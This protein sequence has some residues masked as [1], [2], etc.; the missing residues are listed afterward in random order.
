MISG[1]QNREN[2]ITF[3]AFFYPSVPISITLAGSCV[4]TSILI[5]AIVTNDQFLYYLICK[6]CPTWSDCI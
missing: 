1:I 6:V 4:P 2:S 3:S 5:I